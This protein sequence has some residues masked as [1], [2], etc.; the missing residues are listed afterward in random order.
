MRRHA[1]IIQKQD[2][3]IKEKGRRKENKVRRRRKE[4]I[5]RRL[6]GTEE[7]KNKTEFL[8][9]KTINKN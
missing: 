6:G 8:E 4:E 1:S 3:I 7:I 2:A 9:N 5:G